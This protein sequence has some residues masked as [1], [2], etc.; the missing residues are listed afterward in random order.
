V[1]GDDSAEIDKGKDASGGPHGGSCACG[2]RHGVLEIW[3]PQRATPGTL[4]EGR[5]RA[6]LFTRLY[7]GLK[8]KSLKTLKP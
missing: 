4:Y 1:L 7:P 2:G 6:P 5:E 3:D 8:P